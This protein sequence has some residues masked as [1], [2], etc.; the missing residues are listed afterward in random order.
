MSMAEFS[1]DLSPEVPNLPKA[2]FGFDVIDSIGEGAGSTIYAVTNPST[3]QIY[4]LKHVVRLDEK[5]GRF[6]EQLE[7]E[8]E[9]SKNFRHPN[10]RRAFD[11]KVNRSLL[12]KVTDA[13]LIMELFDGTPL[14]HRL[15]NTTAGVVRVFIHVAEALQALHHLGYVHCDL[16][17]NNILVGAD[18]TV[19]VIDFGQTCRIGRVKP[20]IQGTPDFISPEQVKCEPVT[21]KTD[22]FNFGATLYWALCG[23]KIPTLY[24]LQKGDNS[25]LMDSKI[26]TPIE[27]SPNVT[28][29]LSNLT[30]DCVRTNP[31][32][33]PNDMAEVARRLETMEHALLR[34][35][36][37]SQRAPAH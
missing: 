27:L 11:L 20:R 18:Q 13:A 17:P 15:P 1:N 16:K 29:P 7:A 31:A 23:R 37:S 22:V 14:D 19:K 5:A 8:F 36:R 26:P 6:F 4:A 10:L 9:V 34:N 2:L 33:R 30:M 32:K 24:T 28:E 3:S 21:V 12:R 35:S 25:F